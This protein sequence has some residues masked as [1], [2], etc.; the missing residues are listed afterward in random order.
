MKN[1]K[2]EKYYEK[3]QNFAQNSNQMGVVC[4]GPWC[5]ILTGP[6]AQPASC[7]LNN[8]SLSLG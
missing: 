3:V 5:L 4:V 6:G 2:E 7:T 8:G 1:E